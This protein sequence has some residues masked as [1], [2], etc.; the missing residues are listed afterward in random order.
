MKTGFFSWLLILVFV[1]AIRAQT[2]TATDTGNKILLQIEALPAVTST[3][4]VGSALDEFA[5]F[6]SLNP[7]SSVPEYLYEDYSTAIYFY[8]RLL[9]DQNKTDQALAVIDK[10]SPPGRYGWSMWKGLVVLKAEILLKKAETQS[11]KDRKETVAKAR[12]LLEGLM[13]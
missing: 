5:Q 3:N 12:E 6:F 10:F 13:W 7:L 8:A 11:E 4:N 9:K 1:S 2:N